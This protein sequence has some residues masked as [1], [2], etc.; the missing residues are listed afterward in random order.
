MSH[1]HGH[2][3]RRHR[4]R[5]PTGRSPGEP[6]RIVR[7]P[8]ALGTEVVSHGVHAELRHGC[9]P[10]D[11][12][13]RRAESCGHGLVSAGGG[14][15]LRLH[16][17]GAESGSEALDVHH[18]LEGHRDAVENAERSALREPQVRRPRLLQEGGL[19]D[20]CEGPQ[21]GEAGRCLE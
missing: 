1:R 16:P 3:P 6:S 5:A 11:Q 9:G 7:V 18:V 14:P 20:G 13:A 2:Q 17:S 8:G 12:G 10:H 4:H 21:W 15:P 19:V